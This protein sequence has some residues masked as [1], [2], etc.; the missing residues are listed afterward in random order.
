MNKRA[1]ATLLSLG[2]GLGACVVVG[3][4]SSGSGLPP[5]SNAEPGHDAGSKSDAGTR[6]GADASSPDGSTIG[7]E[8]DGGE[9]DGGEP[10]DAEENDVANSIPTDAAMGDPSCSPN[11]TWGAA[12]AVAGVPTFPTQPLVTMTND[13]LTVAWV[14]D[15]GNGVGSV[16]FAD[17]ASTG[18]AFPTATQLQAASTGSSYLVDGATI[19]DGG[20]AYFAFDRVALSGDGLTLVGVAV[21]GLHLASFTRASRTQP[22][23]PAPME[24]TYAGLA[25]S[26]MPGELLGDPV[27]STDGKDLVYS[28][29]GL[30]TTVTIYETFR[31]SLGLGWSAG[32][33]NSQAA[34][35][36]DAGRRKRPTSMSGDRL[37]LFVWDE[38]GE[39][40]G[41]LRATPTAQF[42]F[43]IAFGD[44]FSIQVNG[45]C[46]RIYYVAPS[47]S[48]Y[49][50]VQ[51]S[52]M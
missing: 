19:T 40:Y 6:P 30:S 36:E 5:Q 15:D 34:L 51:A 23:A 48:Q 33:G 18:D 31:T 52:A 24:A 50:L 37:T 1:F 20:D 32:S 38:A 43:P 22:F 45:A 21:G 10:F 11:Q 35:V 26:L 39:A 47:A 29:Y 14:L 25:Q 46:S 7:P 17:R 49:A 8:G 9:T 2:A 42:N 4:C 12:T 3:A 28:K 16:Y 41:L 27:L 44:R 13:E